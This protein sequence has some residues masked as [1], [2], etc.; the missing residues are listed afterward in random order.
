M[1]I[2][3]EWL[4]ILVRWGHIMAGISW[5]GT[6]FYF[7]WFD[8]SA[9]PPEE[10][11]L[12]ENVRNTLHEIHGGSFYY[13]EQYWPDSDYKRTLAHSGPAQLTFLTG[14]ALI[15][16][17]YWYGVS[18][19]LIDPQVFSLSKPSAILLSAGSIAIAYPLYD[20]LCREVDDDRKIF[21]VMA[22]ATI[23]AAFVFS[24]LF[25]GRAAYLH[26]GAVLGTV[27]VA[28]VRF[29]IVPNHIAMRRQI[30]SGTKLNTR[31]GYL[32]K[33]RSQHNN[34]FT[35][36]VI[37]SMLG[38]HFPLAYSHQYGWVILSLVMAVGVTL[39][40]FRNVQFTHEKTDFRLLA[41]AALCG[42]IAIGLTFV[43]KP[44]ATQDPA[45][46]TDPVLRDIYDIVQLRCST[47]HSAQPTSEDFTSAPLGF[48]LDTLA[49]LRAKASLVYQRTIVTKDMPIGNVTEMTDDERERL[50]AWLQSIGAGSVPDE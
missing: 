4:T 1:D 46:L 12:K 13:H 41:V 31:H 20:K 2:L 35:L 48:M 7:N 25:G 45:E 44:A 33:R 10:K 3:L 11:V 14:A 37:F 6:S 24:H 38:I 36:P 50:R 29:V 17:V 22:L 40:H 5:I 26:V 27:M 39:R 30:Q 15:A 16:L 19:Y 47:C 49:Q 32:A 42:A 8:L 18:I 21:V 28:N 43:P 9:R 23:F 34:Y